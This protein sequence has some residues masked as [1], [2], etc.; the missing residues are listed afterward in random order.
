MRGRCAAT[1]V[2]LGARCVDMCRSTFEGEVLG[3]V[4][5]GRPSEC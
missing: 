3:L 2:A 4:M 5:Q 1:C